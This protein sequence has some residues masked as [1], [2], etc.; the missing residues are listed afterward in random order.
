MSSKNLFDKGK[1]YKVL[2]SVDPDTLGL[3]AESYRNIEAQVVDKNRFI[4]NVDFSSASNFVR[5]GSAKKYYESAFDRIR[6]EYPYDGSAAEKQEF[7]NSSSYLDLYIY[8]NDYPTTTGY[9]VMY[10]GPHAAEADVGAQV[11]GTDIPYGFAEHFDE[12][13]V[14]RIYGGPHTSSNGMVGKTIHSEFSASNIYDSNIYD[15]EGVLS[16]GKQ[17]TRESNLNFDLS[18]GVTT[19]FWVNF[20]SVWPETE[21]NF[22]GPLNQVIYDQ[23]NQSLSS[24]A[25]YGRLLIFATGSTDTAGVDPIRVHLASGS[26]VWDVGFGGSTFTTASLKD[27]WNHIAL[28]FVSSSTQLEANFYVNGNLHQTKTNTTIAALG[29]ITGSLVAHLGAAIHAPS[30]SKSTVLLDLFGASTPEQLAELSAHTPFSGSMDEFRYWKTARTH[31]EIA[32]N[33]FRHVDGGTNTDIANTELGVYFKFNEGITGDTTIDSTVLDYSG[34][35]TNGTWNN[36]PGSGARNSGS[37]IVS[38][39]AAP[40]EVEDPIIYADHPLVSAKRA[41]LV[42]SGSA[43]DHQN[44]SSIYF[45]LPSWIIEEEEEKGGEIL[46]LTQIMGSYFDTLHSQIQEVNKLK[47]ITY[48][49]SSQKAYPFSNRLLESN[50]LFA[51]EIFVDA[52]VLEQFKDQS[53]TEFYEKDLSEVKN[54]IYQNIYNNLVYI[55]KSKGTEKSFRNVIR[56]YGVDDELIK[57]NLYGNNVTHKLR[58]NFRNSVAKRK[59]ADFNHTTRFDAT[60][61]HQTS[62]AN[63]NT[64]DVTFVSC[65]STPST[66]EIEVIFPK[67]FEPSEEKYFSTNFLSSSVFGYHRAKTT[68]PHDFVW[69]SSAADRSLQVYA[70]RTFKNS[71]DVYFVLQNPD[72]SI[73]ATSSVY[74]NIYDDTKWNF[75]IRT[76]LEKKESAELVTGSSGTSGESDI[77]LELYGVNTEL[78]VVK[79]E[80]TINS[81]LAQSTN[82]NGYLTNARRY[83][84]G[85]NRT[86]FTG[87][88]V[89]SSDVKATSLRHWQTFLD[90][91]EVIAHAKNTN[92]YGLLR[93]YESAYVYD[94]SLERLEIPRIETL[95]LH[96]NFDDVSASDANGEFLVN[97]FS[98]GS[99]GKRARYTGEGGDG[100][101]FAHTV[102]NQY[103]GRGF[104]FPVSNT[105]SVAIE[106]VQTA[107]VTPPEVV[108]GE[109]MTQILEFDDETFTKDSR[110]INHF[111]AIEKS[112][113]QTVS[114]EI[115]NM[116]ATIVGF[117]NLIGEP[118]NKYRQEYK[119]LTKLRSLFFENIQNTPD[120]DKYVDFYRWIDSSLS[121]ILKQLIPASANTSDDIRT[122]VE[123]HV[124]E[125]SKYEHKFPT[126]SM[127]AGGPGD[128]ASSFDVA[129]SVGSLAADLAQTPLSDYRFMQPPIPTT[130]TATLTVTDGDDATAI[131]DMIVEKSFITY[132]SSDGTTKR[133]VFTDTANGGVAT[134]TVLSD[135]GNTDTGTGTAGADED[136]G[137]AVGL[138]ITGGSLSTQN[139]ILQQL[140]VAIE[141]STGHNGQILVTVPV[142]ASGQQIATLTDVHPGFGANTIPDSEVEGDPSNSLT[143]GAWTN[144]HDFQNKNS[145]FW[146]YAD[147]THFSL[148]YDNTAVNETRAAIIAAKRSSRDQRKNRLGSI[149]AQLDIED[150]VTRFGTGRR[151]IHGGV[152]LPQSHY[153]AGIISLINFGLKPSFGTNFFNNITVV[154]TVNI[155]SVDVIHPMR[156]APEGK[157]FMNLGSFGPIPDHGSDPEYEG[158]LN[159][160]L[161]RFVP[162]RV[163]SGSAALL[164]TGYHSSARPHSSLVLQ[165]DHQIIHPHEFESYLPGGEMPMQSPFTEKYVGGY[166]SRHQPIGDGVIPGFGRTDRAESYYLVPQF[167][168]AINFSDFN[169]TSWRSAPSFFSRN[170]K[171]KRPV[172]LEN[173][174]IT[175]AS[176]GSLGNYT[177]IREVV[178]VA[179]RVGGDSQFVRNEGVEVTSLTSSVIS[180]MVDRQM[181]F[182]SS[183]AH[184]IIERFSAPGGPETS[185]GSLDTAT[186]QLTVYNVLPFRNLLVRKPLRTLLSSSTSKFGFRPGVTAASADY[187]GLA[188]FHK[189]N[190][191]T[192]KQIELLSSDLPGDKTSVTTASVNDNGF[193]TRPIPQ[194]DLQYSWVT[195]SLEKTGR[196]IEA[197]GYTPK[198]FEYSTSAGFINSITFNAQSEYSASTTTGLVDSPSRLSLLMRDPVSAS[199]QI[200]G[201]PLGTAVGELDSPYVKVDVGTNR[202]IGFLPN[203]GGTGILGGVSPAI[204]YNRGYVY[205]YSTWKQ[206]RGYDHPVAQALRESHI[207]SVLI[208]DKQS[209]TGKGRVMPAQRYGNFKQ[210]RES[211][212][213]S[214]Y[215]P[216]VQM[217]GDYDV[218]S[219]YG[220]NINFYS[221]QE[222]NENYAPMHHEEQVYDK[223]KDLYDDFVGLS[224][225][226]TVYPAERNVYDNRIRQREG[227]TINFWHSDRATRNTNK[228][229]KV[230]FGGLSRYSIWAMD[231][232]TNV[233]ADN[234]DVTADRVSTDPTGELQNNAT[235]AHF[236]TFKTSLTASALYAHKHWVETTASI[237]SP[238]GLDLAFANTAVGGTF[239]RLFLGGGNA[240]WQAGEMAGRIVNGVFVTGSSDRANPAY[241]TYQDYAEE[242][243]LHGKDYSIVPEFR[244]SDHID[245]YIKQMSGDFL[246]ENT[247]SFDIFGA[248]KSTDFP[249]DSSFDEFYNVYSNSDFLKYFDVIKNE[250][251]GIAKEKKLTL[252]C[253][254]LMKFLPYNGFYPA[255][256]T[257]QMATQFSSSYADF[258]S[259]TGDD[260]ILENAKI[261][262]FLETM[263]APGVV[264]N[265]IK[266]GIGLPYP[267]LT[268]SFERQEIESG[269]YAMSASDDGVNKFKFIDFEAAVE[270]EKYLTNLFIHDPH[271]HPSASLDLTASWNGQ[272]D[273]LYRMMASN[274]FG[275]CPDF[276]LPQGNMTTI[277]SLPES[278][279]RFGNAVSGS[280]YVMRLKMYRSMNKARTFPIEYELPQDDPT[281]TDLHETFTMY[282]RPS[283]FYPAVSGRGGPDTTD[284]FVQSQQ[285]SSTYTDRVLDS[286]SGYNWAA[287]PPYYN[288]QAWLDITF[289]A[290]ETKKYKLAEILSNVSGAMNYRYD[291]GGAAGGGVKND[292][293]F[294]NANVVNSERRIRENI[295]NLED[296]L[297]TDGRARIKSVEYDPVTG[298]PTKV[299]DDP[300]AN[301]VSLVIQ[302]K[303]ET[304]MFNFA[305]SSVNLENNLTAPTYASESVPRGMW[306]QFGLPPESP[307]KGI[308]LQAS[309]VPKEW[310]SLHPFVAEYGDEAYANGNAKS[311]V[312]LLGIDQSPRR[313]GEVA[314]AKEVSEAIVAVPFVQE[315]NNKRFFE[316][317]DQVFEAAIAKELDSSNSVRQM[318]VKMSRYVLPPK[319]DFMTNKTITPFAMYIFEFKHTFDK[320]DL[321]H[322]WQNLPPKSIE[323][324]EEKTVTVSHEFL[325]TDLLGEAMA[326][327]L[328]WMVFKV[329]KK[330]VKNYF[331]KVASRSGDNLDD[332]RYKFEFEV[333]GRTRE[334][335]YSYNWPYDFFSLVELVK[336]GAKVDLQAVDKEDKE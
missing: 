332:K 298:Q 129:A 160:E 67:K 70:V 335:P 185:H 196:G 52:S 211:P 182:F 103:T 261:R 149:S 314:E 221:S 161:A 230:S 226:E 258:V 94:T 142:E 236:G 96:W 74:Q 174:Q 325:D 323:R 191:N 59:F 291:T 54:L 166:S 195:S 133:Y 47:D 105:S 216:I 81:T 91:R 125:R 130:P 90:N 72:K 189:V 285:E 204:F 157:V 159:R 158:E 293:G 46:N 336:I 30:G 85:A 242:I 68:T 24:S 137:I 288:G 42:L 138:A 208:P 329:K 13:D 305:S 135:S 141:G 175:T 188:N 333:A 27:T 179:G 77:V 266:S 9:A 97:D 169:S 17:G 44:N 207:V 294:Y 101:S 134:G 186:T 200:L 123:S 162:F 322:I 202:S 25:G 299:S 153:P 256:R 21:D 51:P 89:E 18:K 257:L 6:D 206:I 301:H 215:K 331:S 132:T 234:R 100:T 57:I 306:H 95:A 1:S 304:P 210:F 136:G 116:F 222:L 98:S 19:E 237:V 231:D 124:L 82:N 283:A 168:K 29:E 263:Y 150:S 259:Y 156:S 34:R 106:Y 180:G 184:T 229:N 235:Q 282:S 12:L 145:M 14:I 22:T 113:Y 152:N 193:I 171:V 80:F 83:Y 308:F 31:E 76:Y 15:T 214:K 249:T 240:K 300:T 7:H 93:P 232:N 247:A 120:L 276:F 209:Y 327:K 139:A 3:D 33:Y 268:G 227:Y 272:G 190:R 119:D 246:T 20:N 11:L 28:S 197:L 147:P 62:S 223:V 104:F 126:I 275:E 203:G 273:P 310:L 212:I 270:P 199:A 311:L 178:Q 262:P 334:V 16:L 53:E 318:L 287:T 165:F 88:L 265:S 5:Y 315:A 39:S 225:E 108:T 220:N 111:F 330:A 154:D 69:Y 177:N 66:A 303:W 245:Y 198:S 131:G 181:E 278:D 271:P 254:A 312:D 279:P 115:L 205:G 269:V 155:S 63:S 40:F 219:S 274:F 233:F 317:P 48:V 55:Y 244:I 260:A 78:G 224:Y 110:T 307:D 228:A 286:Y 79:N 170:V 176:F 26:N 280:T 253:K 321:T 87:S 320:D 38:A 194:S 23:W 277:T 218:A 140:K 117:N 183:S 65:S 309:D 86:N 128:A 250:H 290:T 326:D 122:M 43:Y 102:G 99:I 8:D 251:V 328:Q 4:P 267:V 187:S 36:Y 144:G 167:S 316:I 213:I 319:M 92:S 297:I 284:A 60:V 217:I 121:I 264:Y 114:E 143:I 163:A 2:S 252:S 112:M 37:A 58:D 192:L 239:G 172:N 243:R 127:R 151:S 75:A 292:A 41:E 302:P 118:V 164:N 56:C 64:S 10:S 248:T 255:E 295:I 241:D 313:L 50:G 324:V 32:K 289:T 281:Q 73:F 201:F 49:S 296:V 61:T 146:E 238:S 71:K 35:I 84:I 109:D 45:S 148:S 173:I 107:V